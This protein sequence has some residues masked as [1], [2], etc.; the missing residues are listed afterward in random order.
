MPLFSYNGDYYASI[1]YEPTISEAYDFYYYDEP[2]TSYYPYSPVSYSWYDYYE[3][4]STP[5]F[6]YSAYYDS[7]YPVEGEPS[8]SFD[9]YFFD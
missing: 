8:P 5:L 2:T 1:D 6:S 7:Y 4:P 3:Y 9:Y